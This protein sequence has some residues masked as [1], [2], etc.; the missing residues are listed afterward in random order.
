MVSHATAG[1]IAALGAGS[2]ELYVA[3]ISTRPVTH[4]LDRLPFSLMKGHVDLK[5]AEADPLYTGGWG[6]GARVVEMLRSANLWPES[7]AIAERV[8]KVVLDVQP[9]VIVLYYGP[10]AIHF[11][12]LIRRLFPAIPLIMIHNTFPTTVERKGRMAGMIQRVVNTELS[13]YRHWLP[14]LDFFVFASDEMALF[15]EKRFAIRPEAAAILPDYFPGGVHVKVAQ[16]KNYEADD[17]RR[18]IFLGAPERWGDAIDDI[19][20]EF[21]GLAQEGI[22]IFSGAMSEEVIRTGYGFKYPYFSDDEVF[23][24]ALAQYA[25]GFDAALITYATKE[26]MERFRSTLPTRFFTA[27][28]AGIPIAVRAGMFDA[29]EAYVKKYSLG[30]AYHT[31]R[32]LR[33][34]LEDGSALAVYRRNAIDHLSLIAAETQSSQFDAIFDRLSSHA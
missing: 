26:R 29:V 22:T 23:D 9:S 11:G 13:D 30:F 28:T 19:D 4:C 32:E 33:E 12:R 6:C 18:V 14:K 3:D 31:P 7:P 15:A 8:R 2:Y 24:G 5:V 34:R 21:I 25:H 27:L 10:S 20:A 1:R 17:A 16:Q